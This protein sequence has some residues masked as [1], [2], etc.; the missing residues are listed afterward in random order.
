MKAD[1]NF[2]IGQALKVCRKE[3]G[4][5]IQKLAELSGV[6]TA[7]ICRI[8]NLRNEPVFSTA[9][10]LADALDIDIEMLRFYVIK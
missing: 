5:S 7:T 9:C 8:E 3:K 1:G 4:I 2:H 6:P 10:K